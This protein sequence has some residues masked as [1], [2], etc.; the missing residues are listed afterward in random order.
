M[1]P[2]PANQPVPIPERPPFDKLQKIGGRLL[3]RALPYRATIAVGFVALCGASA[4]SLAFPNLV[5]YFLNGKPP[6]EIVRDLPFITAALVG[7]FLLQA[8]CFYTRHYCF[9]ATGFR[10]GA[11]LRKE[12]FGSLL[13]Q[14]IAFFDRTR[15]GD[16]LS[17]LSADVQVVQSA[18]TVN[19]SVALR[20][21]LQ[22]VGGA[23]LMATISIKL[24]LIIL[25]V[26]PLII[27]ASKSWGKRLRALSRAIQ[28][29][30]G[31]ANVIADEGLSAVRVVRIFAGAAHEEARFGAAVE[32]VLSR[33]LERTRFAAFFSSSMVFVVHSS[34]ALVLWFGGTLVLRSELSFWD[35][36]AFI[37]YCVIVAVSFG[38]L[39]NVFD[40]FLHAV[41]AGERIFEVL[42]SKPEVITPAHPESPRADS[43]VHLSFDRVAF[44][45][46]G[47]LDVPV[48]K[49][50]SFEMRRGETVAVVGPSGA[51]K[52]TI[53]AL[54]A[55]FYDPQ[56]G[57]VRYGEVPLPRLDL[58]TLRR[59]I[60]L[61][62]QDTQVFSVSIREN[63]RYGRIGATDAEVEE[64][65]ARAN[66]DAFVRA[67]PQGYDTL[68]GDRG[69]QLSGGQRQRLAIARAILKDP[70]LLI[71][72]EATSALDSENE[73]LV[74]QA[75]QVLMKDRTTM[76]IAHRLSTV[77]HA[78]Q[79]LVLQEGRICQQGT[80][81]QLLRTPGLYKT[82][83][84]YQLL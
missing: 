28:N 51:G 22:A 79:V 29:E 56:S 33:G 21:L 6:Q 5:R 60:S 83:V 30:L 43:P 18:L 82:L 7:L 42:D 74:Q 64:T 25:L 32:R 41:G 36:T 77:Q 54:A 49:E 10:I 50:I 65:A 46:P 78:D 37:L 53:A 52:S 14:D 67:L 80:H 12:L 76:I 16:H 75:L 39:I 19:V 20:Y 68:V 35:L 23:V 61:V 17:R 48:L 2:T 40:E 71:L 1:Q 63:I 70:K 26:V 72:D 9:A 38:F 73:Q 81:E 66:I 59:D 55:R 3:G 4:I 13:N 58:E 69:V 24:T 84:E 31:N 44:A 8:V 47:R 15:V 62:S 11:E 34:I 27:V 45:Y 57:T